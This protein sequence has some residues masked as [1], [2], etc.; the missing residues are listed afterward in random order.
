MKLIFLINKMLRDEIEE[1]IIKKDP[2]QIA[3]KKQ[4]TKFHIEI[5]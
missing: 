1:K 4:K 2:K 5:K 3:I